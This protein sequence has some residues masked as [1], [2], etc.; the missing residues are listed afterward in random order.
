ML[1]TRWRHDVSGTY[2]SSRAWRCWASCRRCGSI[3]R[4]A[5]GGRHVTSLADLTSAVKVNA[6]E[7][8]IECDRAPPPLATYDWHTYSSDLEYIY[9]HCIQYINE[10]INQENMEILRRPYTWLACGGVY[11]EVIYREYTRQPGHAVAISAWAAKRRNVMSN[12]RAVNKIELQVL[13]I[14]T[15]FLLIW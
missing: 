2:S 15:K 14:G 6:N 5:P 8:T 1:R 4:R 12:G 9:S 7:H 10:L 13:S 11:R 3:V